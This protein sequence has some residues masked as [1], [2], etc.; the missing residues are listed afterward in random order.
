MQHVGECILLFGTESTEHVETGANDHISILQTEE[1]S[2][3]Q[4]N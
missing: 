2:T 3:V 1:D 4:K